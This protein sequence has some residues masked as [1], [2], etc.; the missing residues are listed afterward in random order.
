MRD[1]NC[2]SRSD[3]FSVFSEKRPRLLDDPHPVP[4]EGG[5]LAN[6]RIAREEPEGTVTDVNMLLLKPYINSG[7]SYEHRWPSETVSC[8][9]VIPVWSALAEEGG[10]ALEAAEVIEGLLRGF[11]QGIPDH[12]LGLRRWFTPKNHQSALTAAKKIKNTLAKEHSEGRIFGPFTHKEVFR[13]IGFFR[14]SP[15]GSVVNGDGSF[16][17]INDMSFPHDSTTTPLV[18]SL[19]DKNEFDT[20]WDNFKIIVSFFK[21]KTEDVVMA[22]FDWEKAYRQI[23]IH[24]SQWRYLLILD[25]EDQLWLDTRVQFGGVAGCGVF[26]RPADLWKKIIKR[27]FKLRGAF[28]W[29]DDN[30][31]IKE[32]GNETTIEDIVSISNTMGVASNVEKVHDF[33]SE[34]RYIGFVWNS[35]E[36]TVRLPEEK[37]RERLE[38]I[39]C[40]LRPDGLFTFK[41]TE[42]LIGRLV[43]TTYIVPNLV[44]YLSSLHRWKKEWK[45]L[46]A[47]RPLP[48]DVRTDLLEWKE[49]LE[50]FD[51]RRIIPEVEVTDVD[52]VGDAA[53]SF[54]IGVLVGRNWAQFKLRAGW[55]AHLKVSEKGGIAWA[56]NAAIR[57]GIMVVSK[58][59]NVKGKRFM[60]LTDNTTSECVVTKHRSKDRAVNEEWKKI[61][62]LL[63]DLHCDIAAERVKS[64]DNKADELLRGIGELLPMA[65]CVALDMP[66]DLRPVLVQVFHRQINV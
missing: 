13:K 56:E 2:A 59:Y 21:D 40:F 35:L 61:Q 66:V 25:L 32:V 57:L 7:S 63:V 37:L 22:I 60:V 33:S 24:P 18:N 1:S 4:H 3:C 15:M 42:K 30:L 53:S 12:T 31:L 62:R 14:T 49:T 58:V 45:V 54:G 20:T 44:C 27:K 11:H 43:H 65:D 46:L 39:K 5:E 50:S 16:R 6:G 10:F 34:Q 8:G 17:V 48:G 28:R 23:T 36:R 47:K 51:V 52:W 41:D 29:V 9:L 55:K 26:G 19:V 38:N 64:A